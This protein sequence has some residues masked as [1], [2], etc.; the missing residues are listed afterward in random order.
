V[1]REQYAVGVDLGQST[2]P[3][4]IAVLRH[5]ECEQVDQV[6]RAWEKAAQINCRHLQR[7]TL[8]LSYVDQVSAVAT[9][10]QRPPLNTRSTVLVI[11]ETGVGRAVGDLFDDVGLEPLRVTITAG[12]EQSCVGHNR[13]HVSKSIL[14]STLDANLHTKTL[15]FAAGLSEAGAMQAELQDFTR[16]I[17]AAGCFTFQARDGAHDDLTLAVC[18]GLWSIVGRPKPPE[19]AFGLYSASAPR[20]YVA[21]QSSK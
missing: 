17:S 7:L 21:N 2:D 3:T 14:V 6:K 11:D 13:W 15:R 4:A 18:I 16:K 8:G 9:L 1:L 5:Q 10:L 19:A 20:I 12:N